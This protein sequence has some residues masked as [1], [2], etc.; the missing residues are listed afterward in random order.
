MNKYIHRFSVDAILIRVKKKV[1]KMSGLVWTGPYS[2]TVILD[3]S[4]FSA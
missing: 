2:D 1:S 4:K 3:D